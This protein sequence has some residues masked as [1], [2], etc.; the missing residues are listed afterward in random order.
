LWIELTVFFTFCIAFIFS[1]PC[2]QGLFK[3]CFGALRVKQ[4][5]TVTR[6]NRDASAMHESN[7]MGFDKNANANPSMDSHYG[8]C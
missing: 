1:F 3:P 4:R 6:A 8:F 2:L 5:E 7:A